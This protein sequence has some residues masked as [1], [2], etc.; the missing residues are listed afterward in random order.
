MIF[1]NNGS[2]PCLQPHIWFTAKQVWRYRTAGNWHSW[3]IDQ[4]SLT[5]RL[6]QYGNVTIEIVRQTWARASIDEARFLSLEK[7]PVVMLREVLIACNQRP[8]IFARSLFPYAVVKYH[9][10]NLLQLGTHSLG[11][12]LFSQKNIKREQL[13]IA[14][15][16]AGDYYHQRISALLD[17]TQP[18]YWARRSRLYWQ[19]QALLVSE[20]FIGE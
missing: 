7:S 8:V 20:V 13:Q 12:L 4:G 17:E 18:Q 6:R 15:L 1:N 2:R 10:I 14:K 5:Q 3:L 19:R 11:D 16:T 9:G